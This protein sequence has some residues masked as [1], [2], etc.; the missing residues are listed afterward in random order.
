VFLEQLMD[1]GL[2]EHVRESGAHLEQRL[3]ALAGRHAV[4]AE[5]RG[6]GLMWG[7]EL[8]VDATP[9][10]MAALQRGLLVNR[11]DTRVVRLLPPLNIA[12]ADLDRAAGILDEVLGTLGAGQ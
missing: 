7:V 9:V 5:V 12:H 4:V 8:T 6:A 3:R 2:Q 10:V 1:H 11:T